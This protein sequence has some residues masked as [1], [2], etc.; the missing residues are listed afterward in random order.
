M[1][2][3][4]DQLRRDGIGA[5]LWQRVS[6]ASCRAGRWLHALLL[7]SMRR[8]QRMSLATR[9]LLVLVSV[10]AVSTVVTLILQND[11]LTTDLQKSARTRL[12]HATALTRQLVDDHLVNQA[13]R[14]QAVATSPQLIAHLEARHRPTLDHFAERLLQQQGAAAIAFVDCE[15]RELAGAGPPGLRLAAMHAVETRPCEAQAGGGVST[16]LAHQDEPYWLVTMP[17]RAGGGQVGSLVVAGLLGADKLAAWSELS[18][19]SVVVAP[20][21]PEGRLSTV[22]K[23]LGALQLR[24]E[25]TFDAEQAAL[26]NSRRSL[27]TGGLIGLALASI[28][29]IFLARSLVR[30]I[31][32]IQSATEHFGEGSLAFRLDARRSDEVGDVARAINAMLDRLEHNVNERIR[33]EN[34]ISDLAYHDSLT[35][36][37]NRRLLR[38][39]LTA[40]LDHP[41]AADGT[42]AV[43]FIDLDRFKYVNDTLGHT[44]GD[45]LLVEVS[46]RLSAC[47][48]TFAAPGR[49]AEE[50]VLIAR[51][52]GDEFTLLLTDVQDRQQVEGLAQRIIE[53]LAEPFELRG[54][55]LTLSASL[56]IALAPDDAKDAEELLRDSDIAMFHAKNQGGRR[57]EFYA[58]SMLEIA[59]KRLALEANLR[60]ALQHEEFELHYQPKLDLET[61][62]ITGV[63]A[64]IRWRAG[65]EGLIKPD[66]FIPMAE[67]IGAIVP[68]GDWVLQ[69]AIEQALAWQRDGVPPVRIAVNISARQ[70]ERRDEFVQRLEELLRRSG[71]DPSLLELE[72]TEGAMLRD[73][74]AAIAMLE[75]LRDLGVGLSLDDFGTGYS[76]LSYLRRLPI[77]TLKIDRTFIHGVDMHPEDAALVGAIIA[78][79]KVLGL[80]VVVEGVET[81]RQRKF[82]EML[83][84]DEIQGFLFSQ[85]VTADQV[86][87]LLRKSERRARSRRGKD[88]RMPVLPR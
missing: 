85:P 48:R 24:V 16:L 79:A 41:H 23:S 78:M 73:E 5:R 34:R 9:M 59:A 53:A 66:D 63:E 44:A 17:L 71:L 29:S 28:A 33:A 45:E 42:T 20:P 69:K 52:G 67:E 32:A 88:R 60:R 80:R 86:A 38:Q 11:S 15:R 54:Q 4:R 40:L 43:M 19:A 74:D 31:R 76:S 12:E 7:T 26:A 62:R 81:R 36:L 61:K 30:P 51:L 22:V 56:G 64:L 37:A 75:R 46:Q 18:R 21:G 27:L 70:I 3:L 1:K 68:I 65:A 55:D 6:A 35:G 14:F 25:T 2:R 83:G 13:A 49:S 87:E 77:N 8:V 72:I 10:A 57:Y 39:R 47:V 84:C 58:D 50:A 82:L